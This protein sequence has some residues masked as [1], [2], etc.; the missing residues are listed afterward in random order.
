MANISKDFRDV[1]E[2]ETW[3]NVQIATWGQ[4]NFPFVES[5]FDDLTNYG[6]MMKL[7]KN[8]KLIIEN[9]STYEADMKALIQ[10]FEEIKAYVDKYLVDITE[11][12]EEIEN[13][14]Q[15]INDLAAS[16]NEINN[17]L[18]G[19]R[20]YVDTTIG[21]AF[22]TLKQYVDEKDSV[23]QNEIDNLQI[24]AI[25]VYDPTTGENLPLQVVINNIYALTNRDGITAGEFDAL[26]LTASGFDSKD[27]TAYEF[28]SS[29]KTLLS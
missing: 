28:D 17:N 7:M 14:N 15:T 2:F 12:Q 19:L 13:I 8:L 22:N 21:G 4:N 11:I 5:D 25:N 18:V 29:A 26:N 10:A 1:S 27:I 24:G 23:L 20:N 9:Q 16:I 3:L 6:M